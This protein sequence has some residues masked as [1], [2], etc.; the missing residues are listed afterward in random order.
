MK[1]TRT[2]YGPAAAGQTPA[3]PPKKIFDWCGVVIFDNLNFFSGS[4]FRWVV[5]GIVLD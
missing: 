4:K 2:F 3:P 5:V 1:N